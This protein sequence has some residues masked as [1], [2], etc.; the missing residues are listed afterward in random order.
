MDEP[1]SY[2]E[3]DIETNKKAIPLKCTVPTQFSKMFGLRLFSGNIDWAIWKLFHPIL[4]V[5]MFF[6]TFEGT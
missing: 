3:H 6:F 1:S 2:S 4:K 5:V